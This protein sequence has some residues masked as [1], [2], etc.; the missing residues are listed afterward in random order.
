MRA[1]FALFFSNIFQSP[2]PNGNFIPS[3]LYLFIKNLIFII[4]SWFF[5][6][7]SWSNI[8]ILLYE[9]W[10]VIPKYS[11]NATLCYMDTGIKADDIHKEI[12][13][14]ILTRFDTSNYELDRTLPKKKVIGLMK[15]EFIGKIVIKVVALIAKT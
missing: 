9:F 12:A 13:E 1:I 15:D 6:I 7:F 8:K 4:L 11:G 2:F 5:P 3:H 10:Y 14:N